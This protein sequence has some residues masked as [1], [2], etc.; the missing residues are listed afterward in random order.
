MDARSAATAI[1]GGPAQNS[2]T[3]CVL[4]ITYIDCA[5]AGSTGVN[6]GASIVYRN[7]NTDTAG[8]TNLNDSPG[9]VGN[10]RSS[11]S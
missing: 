3:D 4:S 2:P 11:T 9:G 1:G 8:F 6:C 7:D 10:P 5:F